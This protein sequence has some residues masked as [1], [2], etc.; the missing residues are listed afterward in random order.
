LIGGVR[1]ELCEGFRQLPP[2][3]RVNDVAELLGVVVQEFVDG[4]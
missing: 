1:V 2:R 4:A 3:A